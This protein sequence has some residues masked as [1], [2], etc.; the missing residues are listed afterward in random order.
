[1]LQL[2]HSIIAQDKRGYS[3]NIFLISRQK[4]CCG[5]SL[6]APKVLLMST[7]SICFYGE[8]LKSASAELNKA[9]SLS[10]DYL[11]CHFLFSFQRY[12]I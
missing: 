8:N 3:H 7:H 2:S 5:Y 11:F 12:T 10:P 1:M 4:T 9:G 6:E